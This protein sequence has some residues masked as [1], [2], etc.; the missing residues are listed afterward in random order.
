[1]LEGAYGSESTAPGHSERSSA[2]LTA[3]QSEIGFHK[4]LDRTE[5]YLGKMVDMAADLLCPSASESFDRL[6]RLEQEIS[7]PAGLAEERLPAAARPK[8][9]QI[10]SRDR[11]LISLH[12]EIRQY[13]TFGLKSIPLFMKGRGALAGAILLYALD[14]AKPD[15]KLIHQFEDFGFGSLKGLATK[16]IFQSICGE[17][18]YLGGLFNE[19]RTTGIAFR[20]VALGASSQL[21]EQGLNRSTFQDEKERFSWTSTSSNMSR[22]LSQA[23][24]SKAMFLNGASFAVSH[25]LCGTLEVASHGALTDSQIVRTLFTGGTFGLTSG[26]GAE[27]QRQCETGEGLNLPRIAYR[28]LLQSAVSSFAAMPGGFQLARETLFAGDRW[29]KAEPTYLSVLDPGMATSLAARQA[30]EL[31]SGLPRRHAFSREMLYYLAPKEEALKPSVNYQD[32]LNEHVVARR[33]HFRVYDFSRHPES[34]ILIPDAQANEF[35]RLRALEFLSR[36]GETLDLSRLDEQKK[37]RLRELVEQARE[38][39]T[40]PLYSRASLE[41]LAG[42]LDMAPDSR[43]V[44]RLIASDA[45]HHDEL[46]FQRSIGTSSRVVAGEAQPEESEIWLFKPEKGDALLEQFSHEF[47]HLRYTSSHKFAQLFADAAELEKDGYYFRAYARPT[48]D[49][50]L[51]DRHAENYAVHFGEVV[52]AGQYLDLIE[53]ATEAPLRARILTEDLSDILKNV[54]ESIRSKRHDELLERVALLKEHCDPLAKRELAIYAKSDNESRQR[55]LR[56]MQTITGAQS[57]VG[58]EP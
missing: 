55:A 14:Q 4:R 48:S 47:A 43:Y 52:L 7:K 17:T 26:A 2:I 15:D 10:I 57:D 35:A 41:D 39:E 23:A 31:P 8:I 20:G 46:W 30:R 36:N 1:M 5:S 29:S 22:I 21:V 40:H 27:L 45:P 6:Q 13:A 28:G 50:T 33:Q 9:E 58:A 18:S 19:M 49:E 37:T 32:Y 38:L 16:G 53:L 12:E 24:S 42:L 3:L 11:H 56:L 34:Q 51:I 25:G 54:P 44:R